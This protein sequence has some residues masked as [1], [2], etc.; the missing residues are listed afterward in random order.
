MITCSYINN[1]EHLDG[2]ISHFNIVIFYTH[3][4]KNIKVKKKLIKVHYK[5]LKYYKE[6]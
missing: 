2:D 1:I 4:L 3:V 5:F 6:L